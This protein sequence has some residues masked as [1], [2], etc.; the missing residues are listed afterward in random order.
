MKKL[1]LSLA[2]FL[3]ATGTSFSQVGQ[4]TD[5]FQISA[6]VLS[7]LAITELSPLE[8]GNVFQGDNKHIALDGTKTYTTSGETTS[9]ASFRIDGAA[10]REVSISFSGHS[11]IT[12]GT[13][14]MTV[15]YSGGDA[16]ATAPASSGYDLSSTWDPTS[17]SQ[18]VTLDATSADAAV[19]LGGEVQPASSQVTGTYSGTGTITVYY[20]G[21]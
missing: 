13:N 5:D 20:T 7:A 19:Y 10:G 1:I 16:S 4:V 2:L 17:A 8:F 15:S 9:P 3:L 6:T 12:D 18:T 11:S 14:S 21:N